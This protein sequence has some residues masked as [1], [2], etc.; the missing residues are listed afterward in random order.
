[1]DK[2]CP[3]SS[4]TPLPSSND[5]ASGRGAEFFFGDSRAASSGQCLPEILRLPL[6]TAYRLSLIPFTFSFFLT[7]YHCLPL[8]SHYLI[9]YLPPPPPDKFVHINIYVFPHKTGVSVRFE[10][11]KTLNEE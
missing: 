10:G 11:V 1:M 3:G 6:V 9:S 8:I 2:I 4:P 7:F 5:N